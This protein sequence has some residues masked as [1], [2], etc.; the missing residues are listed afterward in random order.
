M[1]DIHI[2]VNSIKLLCEIDAQ[3]DLICKKIIKMADQILMVH[4]HVSYIITYNIS[5]QNYNTKLLC[6]K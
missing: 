6:I 5:K 2:S 3:I 1:C 4:V